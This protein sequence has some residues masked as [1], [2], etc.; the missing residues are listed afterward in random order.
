MLLAIDAAIIDID[1]INT[2]PLIFITLFT[3]F[4]LYCRIDVTYYAII[5]LAD[6]ASQPCHYYCQLFSLP[7]FSAAFIDISFIIIHL[8]IDY[9]IDVYFCWHCFLIGWLVEALL[10]WAD[11]HCLM[12]FARYRWLRWKYFFELRHCHY[13]LI[14]IMPLRHCH[15]H[16]L[17]LFFADAAYHW[18]FYAY[19]WL[20]WLSLLL[21]SPCHCWYADAII[22]TCHIYLG[23]FLHWHAIIIF[24]PFHWHYFHYIYFIHWWCHYAI[25][26]MPLLHWCHLLI[27]TWYSCQP[28]CVTL[29]QLNMNIY[30][31]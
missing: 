29:I 17:P 13:W 15:R 6:I 2:P 21:F 18:Y 14:T 12:P 5:S 4:T 22:W 28:C 10:F 1:Y 30:C 25:Y 31:H 3:P 27:A 16:Y 11:G 8:F 20:W 24:S 26:I 7:L 19:F 23:I 9:A